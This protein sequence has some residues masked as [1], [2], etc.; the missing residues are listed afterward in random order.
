MR[1]R[2]ARSTRHEVLPTAFGFLFL[3]CLLSAAPVFAETTPT[4]FKV[5]F[6]GD[7]GLGSNS[8]AV[9][10]LIKSEGASAVV[11]S[12]DFD[13]TDSPSSWESQIN[14]VLGSSFPYFSSIGNHDTAQWSGSGG[15]QSYIQARCN[16]IG[17]S[18]SGDLGVKSYLT[19]KGIQIL[20]DGPGTSGSGHSTYIHDVLA[21]SNAIWRISSWHKD[22]HLMQPE[23]KSDE[24][25]YA[26]Y[27]ESRKGGALIMTGHAHAYSR[28]WLL[29]NCS[30]QTVASQAETLAVA[31][32][33]PSTSADEGRTIVVVSGLGGTG[34][35]SQSVSGS[36]FAK[37]YTST[38]S[39]KYGALFG[40]FNYNGNP[41]LAKFY[42]KNTSG[43]I[44]DSYFVKSTVSTPTATGP[45]EAS[46]L[47]FQLAPGN[48]VRNQ[49]SLMYNL[50]QASPVDLVLYDVRGHAVR[51]VF[52]GEKQ[53]AGPHRWNWD[54]QNAQNTLASGVYFARLQ[55][56]T[57]SRS[58]RMVVVR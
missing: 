34:I 20:L 55:T 9:L 37:I 45:E 24:T 49:I 19:Y 36:W 26:V 29:S 39:A 52:N 3:A 31:A 4:N 17:V 38:Q 30:T 1:T 2:A 12:G 53:A 44:V 57:A 16:R 43:T 47:A 5:A 32:N 8:V 6:I 28:T 25:G 42:F 50:P 11:H 23:G 27:D 58:I 48:P 51:Q 15:Y 22:Q 35:R 33:N 40:V 21:Q 56:E 54:L 7:Q 46:L 13:Y 18:W 10:N 14:S 41:R